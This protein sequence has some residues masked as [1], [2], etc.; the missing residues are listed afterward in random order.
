M[1]IL[2]NKSVAN[3]VVN[4]GTRFIS[5]VLAGCFLVLL[6]SCGGDW[7]PEDD[8]DGFGGNQVVSENITTQI[9]HKSS[10]LESGIEHTKK[11]RFLNQQADYEDELINYTSDD[12]LIVNFDENQVVLFD[13]GTRT[14]DGYQ[15][16]LVTAT[17]SN[18]IVTLE[19]S[20]TTPGNGCNNSSTDYTPYMFVRVETTSEIVIEESATQA[21][22]N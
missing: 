6:S 9:L 18:G 1:A 11:I 19:V 13:M 21:S 5:F 16:E 10:F 12:A 22:C 3:S 14:V 7:G 2:L 15:L 17:K 8:G 4:I 20:Y